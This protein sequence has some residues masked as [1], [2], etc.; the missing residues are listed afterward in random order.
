MRAAKARPAYEDSLKGN[1]AILQELYR[2]S[3]MH[4]D[5]HKNSLFL[6]LRCVNDIESDW[7]R[8]LGTDG[9]EP[10]PGQ[11]GVFMIENRGFD[12]RVRYR[13][14]DFGGIEHFEFRAMCDGVELR[15]SRMGQPD[16]SAPVSPMSPTGYRS[17]HVH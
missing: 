7:T 1:G 17:E 11:A 8:V 4:P 12:Y 13:P 6:D 2:L 5:L 16:Q 15:Q 3:A 10:R 9:D 14:T